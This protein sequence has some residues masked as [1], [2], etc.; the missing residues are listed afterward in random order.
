[1]PWIDWKESLAKLA[2]P[3]PEPEE[4]DDNDPNRNV[5]SSL[6]SELKGS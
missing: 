3:R 1:M 4:K 2:G 6:E 5:D